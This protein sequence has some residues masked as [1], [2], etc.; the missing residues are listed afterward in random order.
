LTWA[1]WSIGYIPK[2]VAFGILSALLP[3]YLIENINGNLLDFGLIFFFKS[4]VQI[5]AVVLWARLINKTGRCKL[6]INISFL[7]SSLVILL[8]P[9]T[10]D[11]WSFLLS[12]LLLS[13]FY[14]AHMPATRILISETF[15]NSE[16]KSGFASYRLILSIGGIIGLLLGAL[17]TTQLDNGSLMIICGVLVIASLILSLLLI[18]DPT[19]MIERKIMKFERFVFLAQQAYNLAYAPTS[20]ARRLARE[21]YFSRYPN[22]KPLILGIF[23]F[24]LA[25]SMVFTAIPFFLSLRIGATSSLIFSL[26]LINSVTVLI[27]YILLRNN[28]ERNNLKLVKAASILRILFPTLILVSGFLQFNQSIILCSISLA[29]AGFAWPYFS[30]SSTVLWMETAPKN[31]AGIYNATSALGTALGSLMAG[32]ISSNYGYENLF[33]L[34][35]TAFSIALLFFSYSHSTHKNNYI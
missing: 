4:L 31:T 34:S 18:H 16:W 32:L 30:I 28:E 3:I 1:R 13:I 22:P 11:T 24:P 2:E 10:K 8:L 17:W 33:V 7:V 35:I 20:D 15:P 5:P 21:S 12:N 27:G 19:L 25:S 9:F 14:V 29:I 6:F 23:L 26:L